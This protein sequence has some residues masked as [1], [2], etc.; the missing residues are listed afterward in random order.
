MLFFLTYFSNNFWQK[1][2][3][4]YFEK[5]VRQSMAESLGGGRLSPLLDPL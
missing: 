2:I 4:A 3:G 5:K 1:K